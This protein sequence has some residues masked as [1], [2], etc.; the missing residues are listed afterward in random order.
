[1][2]AKSLYILVAITLLSVAGLKRAAVSSRMEV[3]FALMI[4]VCIWGGVLLGANQIKGQA[5]VSRF[6]A[7]SG[8]IYR[9]LDAG[10]V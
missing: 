5:T 4:L 7:Y 10:K 3:L 8:K 2:E 6:V 1:M 9:V